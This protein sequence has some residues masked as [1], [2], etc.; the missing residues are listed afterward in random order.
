MDLFSSTQWEQTQWVGKLA[1]VNPFSEERTQVER[2]LLGRRH[3]RVYR[4]WNSVDGEL[5]V[6]RNLPALDEL[7]ESLVREGLSRWQDSAPGLSPAQLQSWDL[8]CLYWLFSRYRRPMCANVYLGPRSE[9]ATAS[10]YCGFRE[11]FQRTLQLPGRTQPTEYAPEEIFALFHQIHRAFN[12]IF[13]CIAG[14]TLAAASLR[15]SIWQSIFTYDLSRYYRQL[16]GQMSQVTTLVTGESGTGKELVARAIALS[17]Y[18]PFD[19][20]TETFAVEHCRCF[21]AVQ[22]S[23]MPQTLVESALFGH[24]KGAFTGATAERKG[25]FESCHPCGC[26]FLDE[27][28]E[29]SRE[30]QVKL[31]RLLQTREFSR[32]GEETV[33]RF[34]GKV[35]AATNANLKAECSQGNF[36]QD[37]LFRICSDTIQT[38]PLRTL[39]DGQ[40]NELRQFV[41]VLSKRMLE[42][43][44]AEEFARESSDWIVAHL[45]VDY[46]WPGN[47]RELEQ[48]LR[49]LLIRGEY[50]PVHD[51]TSK[52]TDKDWETLLESL[53]WTAQ[54]LM[55]RYLQTLYRQEG[56]LA[57]VARRA[58]LDPRTVKKYLDENQG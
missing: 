55:T 6:N 14:G 45:G 10:L 40:E 8:L 12:T 38:A 51:T 53:P 54:E 23:A 16:R 9:S 19:P 7:C 50:H 48:C 58:Q 20:A 4:V 13:D 27:I 28:G 2:H 1:F 52:T 42:G 29:V 31:L 24:S 33:R 46:P 5:S 30:I 18:I 37:L 35:I 11:D 44:A 57:A 56:T 25:C 17:Q 43:P 49:N 36:R 15:S 26:I 3:Q 22:L 32:L 21:H 41:M 39:L 47:V 34:P